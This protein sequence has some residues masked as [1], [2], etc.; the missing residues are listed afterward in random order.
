M[1]TLAAKGTSGASIASP[2]FFK[3]RGRLFSSHLSIRSRISSLPNPPPRLL[4][5]G[6]RRQPPATEPPL[7]DERRNRTFL[8]DA[9]H[10]RRSLKVLLDELSRSGSCPLRILARDGDWP[11]EKLRVVIAFLADTGR[12]TEALQIFYQWKGMEKSR[13][14]AINY[15]KII[16][17]LCEKDLIDKAMLL[18]QEM[19]KLEFTPSVA[20]YNAVIHGFARI[21]E[22]NKSKTLL[23]KMVEDGLSPIPDYLQHIDSG[24][25]SWSTY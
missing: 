19:E 10:Q 1:S 9:F 24:V 5:R 6:N 11:F 7:D 21:K 18:F 20:I 12:I 13:A 17:L 15:S 16:T 2:S 25:F 23:C 8:V 14:S 4:S 22:F 3:Q